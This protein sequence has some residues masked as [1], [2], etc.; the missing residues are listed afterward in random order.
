[1]ARP[2][3]PTAQRKVLQMTVRM[4]L[5]LDEGVAAVALLRGTTKSELV[6]QYAAEQIRLE[7][8]RDRFCFAA[9]VEEIRSKRR[10]RRKSKTARSNSQRPSGALDSS[11]AVT[12][13]RPLARPWCLESR[14]QDR[15]IEP[16]YDGAK[17]VTQ[18]I[19][20][21]LS[22]RAREKKTACCNPRADSSDINHAPKDRE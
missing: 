13:Q 17:R 14:P 11:K 22:L 10:A 3:L 4:R 1:M 20:G 12:E 2:K 5:D 16:L 8:E 19:R 7:E 9:A 21:R 15:L 18:P 6:S